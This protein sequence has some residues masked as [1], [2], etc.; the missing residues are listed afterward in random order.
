MSLCFIIY[1]YIYVCMCICTHIHNTKT[2][3]LSSIP[4]SLIWRGYRAFYKPLK[5]LL[6]YTIAKFRNKGR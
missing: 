4:R 6:I 1:V 2:L 5:F 3:R